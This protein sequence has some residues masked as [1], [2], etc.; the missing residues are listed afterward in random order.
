MA[1]RKLTGGMEEGADNTNTKV[2]ERFRKTRATGQYYISIWHHNMAQ[3]LT[4]RQTNATIYRASKNG[5]WIA[6]ICDKE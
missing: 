4:D 2:Q 1:T 6:L 3:R 5:N